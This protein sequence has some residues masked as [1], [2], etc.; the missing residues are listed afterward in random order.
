MCAQT[1]VTQLCLMAVALLHM[2]SVHVHRR[3]SAGTVSLRLEK[4]QLE[5]SQE[6][7]DPEDTGHCQQF[8]LNSSDSS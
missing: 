4:V 3:V 6:G 7:T 2:C 1:H 5:R 8:W